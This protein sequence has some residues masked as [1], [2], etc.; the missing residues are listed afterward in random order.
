MEKVFEQDLRITGWTGLKVSE[1][2]FRDY[3]MGRIKKWRN[4]I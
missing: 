1:Q 3:R 2:D 4:R